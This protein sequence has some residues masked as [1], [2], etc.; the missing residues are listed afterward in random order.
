MEHKIRRN[1][2]AV[3]KSDHINK[4]TTILLC[5]CERV[6][7]THIG[8]TLSVQNIRNTFLIL[9]CMPLCP[10]NSLN[11]SGHGLQGVKV[12]NRD[13]GPC[14]LQCFPQLCQV[15]WM[16]FGWWTIFYKHGN[17][18]S[19]KNPGEMQFMSHSNWCAWHQLQYPVQKHFNLLSWQFTLNGTHT[20]SMCQLSQG[21][22]ILL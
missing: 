13:A 4:H 12:S 9:S 2:W 20:K 3:L 8:I 17:V 6:L 22:K 16:S 10:Q 15:G 7:F 18:L 5:V 1:H 11:S 21:L 19:V 14:S